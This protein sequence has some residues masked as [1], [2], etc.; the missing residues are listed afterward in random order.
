MK[1]SFETLQ[2]IAR[3][4]YGPLLEEIKRQTVHDS[5]YLRNEI[6]YLKDRLVF[7]EQV[8]EGMDKREARIIEFERGGW[9]AAAQSYDRG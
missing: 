6:R 2:R 4:A 9:E 5:G 3:D 8:L 7:L 1:T